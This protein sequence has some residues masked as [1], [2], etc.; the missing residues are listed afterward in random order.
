M[1]ADIHA[2]QN[3]TLAPPPRGTGEYT[4]TYLIETGG[5]ISGIPGYYGGT[6]TGAPTSQLPDQAGFPSLIQNRPSIQTLGAE[7]LAKLDVDGLVNKTNGDKNRHGTIVAESTTTELSTNSVF[8]TTPPRPIL[9]NKV[10]YFHGTPGQTFTISNDMYFMKGLA[11]AT[12]A[13]RGNGVIVVDGNLEVN[14]NLYY[15]KWCENDHALVCRQDT[16][17]VSVGGTCNDPAISNLIELPSAAIIVRGNIYINPLVHKVSAVVVAI[18]NPD[19][20]DDPVTTDV[21]ENMEGIVSSGRKAPADVSVARSQDDTW[22]NSNTTNHPVS[23]SAFFGKDNDVLIGVTNGSAGMMYESQPGGETWDIGSIPANQGP[24]ISMLKAS[25]GDI[26]L[27]RGGYPSF[28]NGYVNRSADNGQTWVTSNNFN[29]CPITTLLEAPNHDIFIGFGCSKASVYRLPYGAPINGGWV[30]TAAGVGGIDFSGTQADV[31]NSMIRAANGDIIVGTTDSTGGRVY[32]LTYIG[33]LWDNKWNQI[34]NRTLGSFGVSALAQTANGDMYAGTNSSP[35][36]VFRLP[37]ATATWQ[38]TGAI[39]LPGGAYREQAVQSYSRVNALL[40]ASTGVL[41]A[42]MGGNKGDVFQYNTGT[43]NWDATANMTEDPT[44]AAQYSGDEVYPR[45]IYVL[46]EGADHSL[47]AGSQVVFNT[48]QWSGEVYKTTDWGVTWDRVFN[49]LVGGTSVNALLQN[50]LDQGGT[51]FRSMLRFSLP[52]P[53]G[54]EIKSAYLK[55]QGDGTGSGEFN[56]RLYLIDGDNANTIDFASTP[57]PA[58]YNILTSNSVNFPIE[59]NWTAGTWYQTPDLKA[60]VQRF[61]NRDNYGEG[62]YI[63][64]A[65]KEGDAAVGESRGFRT[66]DS[67]PANAPQLIIEY[68][69]R[70]TLYKPSATTDD[71]QAWSTGSDSAAVSQRIGWNAGAMPARAERSFLRLGP[72][73]GQAELPVEAEIIKARLVVTKDTANADAATFQLR[74]G[75]LTPNNANGDFDAFSGNPYLWPVRIDVSEMAED[76]TGAWTTAGTYHFTDIKRLIQ[77][78]VDDAQYTQGYYLGLS[79]RRGENEDTATAGASRS[80]KSQE[81]GG[82]T[83]LEIDYQIPLSVSGLFVAGTG[84]NFDRKYTKNLA[85]AEQILY[86]GRVV[87]NTPPGLSDFITALPIYHRVTP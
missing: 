50:A 28:S 34:E 17:C 25:N 19:T 73:A 66:F 39:Q 67:D 22:V 81:A 10:Y 59:N 9:N 29:D 63:G 44:P 6:T 4:S 45:S 18:D 31:V 24:I 57:N 33:P 80:F 83:Q 30:N 51:K 43:N 74:Q 53:G 85:P 20:V 42:G 37:N 38:S 87:A 52:I 35:A 54:A 77:D 27:G 23:S 11:T 32:R 49:T 61:V 5:T 16:D 60:I 72:V 58:L 15:Q 69:P 84:Y 12:P 7:L 41:Y 65:I 68:G 71:V 78:W 82:A 8:G 47:Y 36:A 76:V 14:A 2:S 40:K 21:V 70:R 3:I 62:N 56:A 1:F 86:D 75:L 79:L 13:T 26:Y 48:S 64:L 55:L 46:S